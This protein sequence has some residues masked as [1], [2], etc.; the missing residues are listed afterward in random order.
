MWYWRG[1][2]VRHRVLLG[3]VPVVL[4]G[5]V[6]VW[7]WWPAP[8]TP[9]IPAD[10]V[11]R[12]LR[13]CLMSVAGDTAT[14]PFATAT[15][16]GMQAAVAKGGVNAQRF[17]VPDTEVGIALPY[18]NGAIARSCAVVVTVGDGLVPAVR[19]VATTAKDKRF[20]VVDG[21]LTLPNVTTINERV[22]DATA[23]KVTSYL[24]ALAGR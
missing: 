1:M 9:V 18:L 15:W 13:A 10:N 17:P 6:A 23:A 11:S 2:R 12:N 19:A 24:L 16:Q 3:L 7:V 5:A 21:T 22:P 14:A 4:L 8:R 20:L